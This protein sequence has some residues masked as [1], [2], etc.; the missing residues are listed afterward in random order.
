MLRGFNPQRNDQMRSFLPIVIFNCTKSDND[1][2]LLPLRGELK[3]SSDRNL[4]SKFKDISYSCRTD[5]VEFASLIV[6]RS[7]HKRSGKIIQLLGNR[8]K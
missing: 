6:C 4:E 3:N 5:A 2:L 8:M 7:G 1:S